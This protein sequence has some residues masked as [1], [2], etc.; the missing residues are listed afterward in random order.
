MKI[1][2]V[3]AGGLLGRHVVQELRASDQDV[4]P[5]TREE[6]DITD[7][8]AVL[9]LTRGADRIVNCAAYTNVEAAESNDE[10]AYRANALGPE[11]LARA[12]D[13]HGSA[14]VHVST[15]FVF[16][17][18]KEAPY[19]ELDR[20]APIGVYARSKWA[21]EVL[22][23]QVTR[24]VFVVRVQGVYGDGGRN[25]AS[26]LRDLLCAGTPLRIDGER[27]VQ[28]TWARTAA[29]QVLAIART[30]LFGTYHVSARG[31]TTWADF[32]QKLAS[33][34]GVP[35]TCTSVPTEGLPS[36]AVRPK[37][38]LFLHRMIELRG[39][40]RMPTWQDDLDA[41]LERD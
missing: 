6:C 21:G 36:K 4:V 32:A 35:S 7:L 24:S 37:N 15:D 40:D 11:N 13:R 34:L 16:D 30:D 3:G 31:K 27:Q 10:A 25:F 33:R 28:P 14:L 23:R 2:V 29:R 5:L 20:P 8:E 1:V 41:Y 12:A 18:Q 39:L 9:S 22:A 19:D 26:R 17:G 38:S